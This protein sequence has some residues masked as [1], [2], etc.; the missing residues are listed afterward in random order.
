MRRRRGRVVDMCAVMHSYEAFSIFLVLYVSC[1][2]FF[3]FS[4]LLVLYLSW[5]I[6]SPVDRSALSTMTCSVCT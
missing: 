2:L 5:T 1:S 3:L 4:I 6:K